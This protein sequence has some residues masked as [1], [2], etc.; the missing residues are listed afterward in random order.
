[1]WNYRIIKREVEGQQAQY[2]LYEVMYNDNK[3]IFAH[4]EEPEVWAES[5]SELIEQLSMML[6]DAIRCKDDELVLGEIKF[7]PAYEEGDL[8][9]AMTIEEFESELKEIADI[10]YPPLGWTDPD[11]DVDESNYGE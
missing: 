3:E 11:V 4:T 1:M 5:S 6:S 10:N 7:A 2:G 8:S 9:E